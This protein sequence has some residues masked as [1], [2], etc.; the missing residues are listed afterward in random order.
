MFEIGAADDLDVEDCDGHKEFSRQDWYREPDITIPSWLSTDSPFQQPPPPQDR[1]AAV[2]STESWPSRVM[3]NDPQAKSKPRECVAAVGLMIRSQESLNVQVRL[4]SDCPPPQDFLLDFSW[5]HQAGCIQY[6]LWAL[7]CKS[8][9]GTALDSP[10]AVADFGAPIRVFQVD[11]ST[12]LRQRALAWAPSLLLLGFQDELSKL[13]QA[14]LPGC[15]TTAAAAPQDLLEENGDL[16]RTEPSEPEAV[17]SER[18]PGLGPLRFMKSTRRLAIEGVVYD[19]SSASVSKYQASA[20]AHWESHR[21]IYEH[22]VEED[23]MRRRGKFSVGGFAVRD[24][25]PAGGTWAVVSC[26]I[27]QVSRSVDFSGPATVTQ[28]LCFVGLYAVIPGAASSSWALLGDEINQF[29]VF[30]GIRGVYVPWRWCMACVGFIVLT[31]RLAA[32]HG[33]AVRLTG[34]VELFQPEGQTLVVGV[35]IA[36]QPDSS[37]LLQLFAVRSDRVAIA[38]LLLFASFASLFAVCGVLDVATCLQRCSLQF[39]GHELRWL[40]TIQAGVMTGWREGERARDK[41][42]APGARGGNLS[43]TARAKSTCTARRKKPLRNDKVCGLCVHVS[44][45]LFSWRWLMAVAV[46]LHFLELSR[47]HRADLDKAALAGG[48][49]ELPWHF[50]GAQALWDTSRVS[51]LG[52]IWRHMRQSLLRA[53]EVVTPI[54]PHELRV[55]A[56]E[57]A[58]GLAAQYVPPKAHYEH[59]RRWERG[60]DT[61]GNAELHPL[62]QLISEP[63]IG[64]GLP[65]MRTSIGNVFGMSSMIPIF[66]VVMVIPS[67]DQGWAKEINLSVWESGKDAFDWYVKS[68]DLCLL[69]DISALKC[70]GVPTMSAQEHGQATAVTDADDAGAQSRQLRISE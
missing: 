46:L 22:P 19:L 9:G 28:A 24:R 70:G 58:M 12:K 42:A 3:A 11:V 1:L 53:H 5:L 47:H 49:A 31:V 25:A 44:S 8:L 41:W 59:P 4:F 33:A 35:Y 48:F 67:S 26:E 23:S 55:Y 45:C 57:V 56:C 39:R 43:F 40:R 2:I 27:V 64:E 15:Y 14:D 34:F 7:G 65:N 50:V 13:Q 20:T 21:S 29:K 51:F 66:Q 6:G 37:E 52:S 68:K 54:L 16:E 62:A 60:A 63:P 69:P 30:F 10:R 38:G 32:G 61:A 17:V 36:L 18:D